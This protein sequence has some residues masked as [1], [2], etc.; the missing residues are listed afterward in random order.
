MSHAKP[1]RISRRAAVILGVLKTG[2]A[3]RSLRAPSLRL[4]TFARVFLAVKIVG[5]G[6]H[7]SSCNGVGVKKDRGACAC[8]STDNGLLARRLAAR[9]QRETRCDSGNPSSALHDKSPRC[10]CVFLGLR[11]DSFQ[12]FS[13][14]NRDDPEVLAETRPKPALGLKTPEETGSRA[15]QT[16]RC[17]L[18]VGVWKSCNLRTARMNAGAAPF[19]L[20]PLR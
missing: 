11:H 9:G 14:P 7:G 19:T 17:P 10:S 3:G 15:E 6:P 8:A 20:Q 5:T 12:V 18:W 4:L 16:A 13:N 1:P 2:W